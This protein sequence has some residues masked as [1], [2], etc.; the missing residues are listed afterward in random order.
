MFFKEA[1]SDYCA[2]LILAKLFRDIIED[3]KT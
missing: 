3:S 1:N 2:E